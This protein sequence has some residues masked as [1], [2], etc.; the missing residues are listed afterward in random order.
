VAYLWVA[1]GAVV[2]ASA[3]YF[4]SGYIAKVFSSSF[5]YG[6]L[7]INLSGS[8]LLGS[9]SSGPS[10]CSLTPGGGCSSR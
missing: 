1:L 4:I 10:A 8:L 3:R 7:V 5:P 2:G 9:F 6:T